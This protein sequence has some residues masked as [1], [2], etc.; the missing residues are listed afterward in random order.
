MATQKTNKYQYIDLLL[1]VNNDLAVSNSLTQAL[2]TLVNITSSV[3]G[4]E[5]GTVF[6][7]DS[8]TQEL[9]SRVAQGNLNR[10]IRVMSNQGIAGWVFTNNTGAIVNDAYKDERFHK[11]VDMRT[12]YRTKSTVSYT[13]LTLPTTPYV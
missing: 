8:E 2:D 4:A 3:I 10:E 12:G 13:H 5:R 11:L 1:Q 9:Y 6:I 7:N